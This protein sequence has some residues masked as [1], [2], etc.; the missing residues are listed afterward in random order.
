VLGDELR[1]WPSEDAFTEA[2]EFVASQALDGDD[3][4]PRTWLALMVLLGSANR[5]IDESGARLVR[6]H[7]EDAPRRMH[8]GLMEMQSAGETITGT[9]RGA[10]YV[11][12]R[13]Q[14]ALDAIAPEEG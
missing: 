6:A 3:R 7:G 2:A 10:L 5:T 4:D 9:L 8:E 11:A 12:M 1:D 14:R 13:L